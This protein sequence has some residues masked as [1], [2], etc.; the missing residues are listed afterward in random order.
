MKELKVSAFNQDQ[1]LIRFLERILK[2]AG[3]SFLYKM[4]RKKNITLNGKKASGNEILKSGD[5]VRVFFSDE[6]FSKMAGSDPVQTHSASANH[7]Y[8][9]APFP[10]QILYED[11]DLL[12]VNK[13][14]GILSQKSDKR[15]DSMNEYLIRYCLDQ[16]RLTEEDLKNFRPSVINRLDRNTSGI[17]LFGKTIRGL[18]LGA[19]L[20]RSHEGQKTYHCIVSGD[21]SLFRERKLVRGWLLKDPKRNIV[22]YF[23]H[24]I[25][26]GLY[27]EEEVF[28]LKRKGNYSLLEVVLHTGRS[29]QIRSSLSA[30]ACPIVN[31]KKYGGVV[32][33]KHPSGQLLHA[34]ALTLPN[35]VRIE[36][37][38]PESFSWFG[39]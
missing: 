15:E 4:L 11:A 8:P 31:D 23:D 6:T 9:R 30:L 38:D 13:P 14:A 16:G 36:C 5:V 32:L 17:L 25:E 19:D 18:H 10:L 24:E 7:S 22:S 34:A 29:H 1:K 35:G 26:K 39:L 3:Y 21:S 20:V 28:L 33:E 2:N 27:M 12:A 37:P